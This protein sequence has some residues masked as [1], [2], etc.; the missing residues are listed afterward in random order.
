MTD[1]PE[2]GGDSD[3]SPGAEAT[4]F[5]TLRRLLL[6]QEQR[7]IAE[8]RRRLD[9]L[10]LTA[11]ELAECLPEALAL[12]AGRDD[13]LARAL[14]P[15]LETAFGESV[16]SHPQQ[17]ADAIYPAL[18]PAIR[19]AITE[20]IAGLVT[21]INRSLESSL[22]IQGI[23]WRLE[24]WRSGVPY[25]QIVIKHALVY[26][27]E[28]VYLID[29]RSGLLLAHVTA[30]D[31][32][33]PDADVIS[34]MLT[35]I[36]D[37][38]TDSFEPRADGGLRTFSVGDVTVLVE[39]GPRAV[40]AAVVRGQ[41]PPAL[42]ERLQQTLELIHLRFAGP[43]A[44]FDGD[45]APFD[46]ARPVLAECL[47]TVV[48]TRGPRRRR[49][50]APRAAW[51]LLLVAVLLGLYFGI[52][53]Q[54]RWSGALRAL[55]AEPGLVLVAAD[56]GLGG[57]RI[58]GLRDPL[59]RSPLAVLAALGADTSRVRGDWSPYL[60]ADS[61]IVVRR[62]ERNLG[63]PRD[64]RLTVSGDTL[65]ASGRAPTDWIDRARAGATRIAGVA[66]FREAAL[67]PQLSDSL[68]PVADR[69]AGQRVFFLPGS[70]AVDDAS[71]TATLRRVAA[72]WARLNAGLGPGWTA[73]LEA[74]GRADM[75]GPLE[76]NRMLSDDRAR[77][78]ARALAGLGLPPRA[79]DPL[80]VGI[81]DP[82]PAATAGEQ[83]RLNRSVS[84]TVRLTPAEMRTP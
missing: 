50:L 5:A 11:E 40:L 33:A 25:G 24:A 60:S 64:T 37:F 38:V 54:H 26:R 47:E 67:T 57:W 81:R 73:I 15:T 68:R 53:A 29:A 77:A 71:D 20:A 66:A 42:L 61:V 58:R 41:H 3:R 44:A 32:A 6:S 83:S 17:I 51:L 16:R 55:A 84:F 8:L 75:T 27:V 9:A 1:G 45:A 48:D 35:A 70:A 7:D 74:V 12:Q 4:E 21:S 46:A 72:D 69:I 13:R 23:K 65:V 79:I 30:P 78:T 18:G 56:R 19:K 80:G 52:R 22:S 76:V 14:A 82:L 63:R 59:A 31:L 34:G 62:A 49:A 43:L 36:R 2:P 39:A 28:Q 10:G